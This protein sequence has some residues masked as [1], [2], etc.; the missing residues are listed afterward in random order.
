MC[1]GTEENGYARA[2]KS[3]R[4]CT[5]VERLGTDSGTKV[6]TRAHLES[7]DLSLFPCLRAE[8]DR[9]ERDAIG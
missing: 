9:Q 4:A 1:D 2:L 8:H 7:V 5:R 3:D 6:I